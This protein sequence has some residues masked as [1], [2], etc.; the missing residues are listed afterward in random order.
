MPPAPPA[1]HCA[2]G[3]HPGAGCW[4]PGAGGGPETRRA[5]S[6]S[7]LFAGGGPETRRPPSKSALFAGGG[8]ETRRPPALPAPPSFFRPHPIRRLAPSPLPPVPALPVPPFLR[9]TH[10]GRNCVFCEPGGGCET[11]FGRNCVFSGPGGGGD[12]EES[13]R[14]AGTGGSRDGERRGGSRGGGRRGK[15]QEGW[16]E[17]AGVTATSL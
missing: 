10:F 1:R 9:Q 16:V 3:I 4:V 6:K 14:E 11:R 5:P 2:S 7:A 17:E 12:T 8:P 13:R 15:R